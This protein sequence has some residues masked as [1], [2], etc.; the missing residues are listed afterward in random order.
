MKADRIAARDQHVP[1]H[2][3]DAIFPPDRVALFDI[4]VKG[5]DRHAE[6][7]C[8]HG[9]EPGDAAEADKAQQLA[10]QFPADQVRAWPIA[11]Q[12]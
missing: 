2:R 10:V 3:R 11:G 7:P 1:V 8:P 12:N 5:V 6:G 9:D 4:G